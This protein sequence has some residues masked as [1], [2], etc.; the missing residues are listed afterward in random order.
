[1]SVA[2]KTGLCCLRGR[3]N[4][5][6]FVVLCT[7]V[8]TLRACFFLRCVLAYPSPINGFYIQSMCVCLL[9]CGLVNLTLA[10]SLIYV[11][12]ETA[13]FVETWLAMGNRARGELR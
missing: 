7:G 12:L 4:W 9:R 6:Y 11:V 13:G 3:T 5:S 2:E 10:E 8:Y 1:M